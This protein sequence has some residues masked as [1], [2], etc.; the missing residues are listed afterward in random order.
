V[1]SHE[2]A[3]ARS[4]IAAMNEALALTREGVG[5]LARVL[6]QLRSEI[7]T[8]MEH[9]RA[10][11]QLKADE[12]ALHAELE[13]LEAAG[14]GN[15][16]CH[17]DMP[18]AGATVSASTTVMGWAIDRAATSGTGVDRVEVYLDGVLVGTATYGGSRADVANH[19]GSAG[20]SRS[21]FSYTLNLN[22][23]APG[24]RTI[25]V[26]ARSTLTGME[27]SYS[28]GVTVA[29]EANPTAG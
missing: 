12:A 21:G 6:A 5:D 4:E 13:A 1:M 25:Q 23:V 3:L 22:G 26:R 11:E 18:A 15:P 20:F 2:I 10:I 27:A 29:P 8:G 24:P 16:M 14:E 7:G 19:F 28:L 17:I 9:D